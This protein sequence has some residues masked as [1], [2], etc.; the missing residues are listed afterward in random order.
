MGLAGASV[1]QYRMADNGDQERVEEFRRAFSQ[2]DGGRGAIK[3][4]DLGPLLRS[5]GQNLP[6]QELARLTQQMGGG[7]QIQFNSFVQMM[8]SRTSARES[9]QDVLASF[10]VFDK[11]GTGFIQ[12]Q[13]LMEAMRIYGDQM[14]QQEVDD[15]VADAEPDGN[16]WINYQEF[17]RKITS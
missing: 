9:Y 2:F 5:L 14:T 8:T 7:G 13:A 10:T 3:P 6:Q 11:E 16:N 4:Q 17:S 12:S 15:M 1:N